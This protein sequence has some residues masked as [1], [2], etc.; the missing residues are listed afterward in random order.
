[1]GR[2]PGER[3]MG[4]LE[5]RAEVISGEL[6]SQ[7]VANTVWTYATIRRKPGDRVMGLL[8]GRAEAISGEFT[9]QDVA[10]TL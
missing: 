5:G 2:K 10:N 8:E 7:T 1:M 6:N 4:L 3:V 9:S